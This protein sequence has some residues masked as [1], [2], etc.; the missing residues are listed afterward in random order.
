[1]R[2]GDRTDFNRLRIFIAFNFLVD[3]L[4]F[5]RCFFLYRGDDSLAAVSGT[6]SALLQ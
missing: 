1:M 6:P 2:V 4:I 5:L 3:L